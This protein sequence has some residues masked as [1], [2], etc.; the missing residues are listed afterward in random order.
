MSHKNNE[1]VDKEWESS[2]EIFMKSHE[3]NLKHF[4]KAFADFNNCQNAQDIKNCP[5]ANPDKGIC[6]AARDT[7]ITMFSR[8]LEKLEG[9]KNV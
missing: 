8:L 4:Y 5:N 1:T 7:F 2:L 6:P 3:K 9:D